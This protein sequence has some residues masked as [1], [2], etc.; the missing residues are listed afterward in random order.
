MIE[1]SFGTIPLKRSPHGWQ[2]FLIQNKNGAHWGFPKG[3]GNEG[4]APFES[5][6][7]E[8]YEETGLE[9]KELLLA[10]PIV[11]Q[12]TFEREGQQVYKKVFYFLALVSGS[13][14]LQQS[15][16]LAGK[17]FSIDEAEERL[18]FKE[19]KGICEKIRCL[20]FF[21]QKD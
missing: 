7:R 4:E 20:D 5:A 6:A 16:I 9:I 17:W 13:I 15:E 19:S 3:K 11:E 14:N 1:E 21:K 10:E 8:L 12:Y 2:I 18:T